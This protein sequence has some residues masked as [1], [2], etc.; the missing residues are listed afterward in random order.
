MVN[1]NVVISWSPPFTLDQEISYRLVILNKTSEQQD[2]ITTNETIYEIQ[3]TTLRFITCDDLD[4]TVTPI[5]RLGCGF[6]CT[7]LIQSE[8]DY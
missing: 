8:G 6:N 1:G 7:L 4:V 3:S 5:N 2:I